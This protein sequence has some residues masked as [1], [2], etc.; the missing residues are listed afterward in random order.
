MDARQDNGS[1]VEEM[2]NFTELW[3]NQGKGIVFIVGFI[4][5]VFGDQR[6][7]RY[8]KGN[9]LVELVGSRDIK[10]LNR[11]IIASGHW[12]WMDG[13]RR[14]T[15]DTINIRGSLGSETPKDQNL[16]WI[17]IEWSGAQSGNHILWG[18]GIC[19]SRLNGCLRAELFT[20]QDRLSAW[21]C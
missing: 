5:E 15:M 6:K 3:A 10:T 18:F 16:L 2:G 8:R 21:N 13:R 9:V 19:V 7:S 11:A 17:H 1:I 12:T 20:S 4:W 14:S